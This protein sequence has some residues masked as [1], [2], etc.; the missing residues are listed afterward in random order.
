MGSSKE[1]RETCGPGVRLLRGTI[2]DTDLH[3]EYEEEAGFLQF[4][5]NFALY[6]SGHHD[7]CCVLVTPRKT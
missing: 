5:P 2:R 4:Y 1:G 6:I 7:T 3:T